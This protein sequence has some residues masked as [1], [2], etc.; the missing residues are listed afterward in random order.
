MFP[1]RHRLHAVTWNFS[2]LDF[3]STSCTGTIKDRAKQRS[4]GLTLIWLI[5][6]LEVG[7]PLLYK[8]AIDA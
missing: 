2:G 1:E 7:A 6:E 5:A 3:P 8:R 4:S